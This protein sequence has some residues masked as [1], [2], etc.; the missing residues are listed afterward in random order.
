MCICPFDFDKGKKQQKAY[1]PRPV[2]AADYQGRYYSNYKST[3]KGRRPGVY[4]A[5]HQGRYYGN[6]KS[7]KKGRYG[8]VLVPDDTDCGCFGGRRVLRG[9]W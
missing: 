3:R 4:A 6:Y 1:G 9:R 8:D 5:N 2:Y 7:T